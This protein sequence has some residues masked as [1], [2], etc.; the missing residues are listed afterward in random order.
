MSGCR[1][2][3]MSGCRDAQMSGC[4]QETTLK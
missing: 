2:A 4:I 1:D 3:Q